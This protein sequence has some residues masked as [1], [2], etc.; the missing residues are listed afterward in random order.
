MY[1]I[2]L[3]TFVIPIFTVFIMIAF[4]ACSQDEPD[5]SGKSSSE[6]LMKDLSKLIEHVPMEWGLAVSET[7][8]AIKS[9]KLNDF[10]FVSLWED[11]QI[12]GNAAKEEYII[13]G[14]EDNKLNYVIILFPREVNIDCDKLLSTYEYLGYAPYLKA[15]ADPLSNKLV[16]YRE[17]NLK[18]NNRDYSA[19]CF[20]TLE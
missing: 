8:E 14:Y 19:L 5:N 6:T 18:H 3:T 17:S 12:Y 11:G 1:K 15:Y 4:F 9:A 20:T 7:E 16:S 13:F 10:K 2:K